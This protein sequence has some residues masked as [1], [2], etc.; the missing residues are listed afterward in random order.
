MTAEKGLSLL[1]I[2]F[3]G[4]QPSLA[5]GCITL[6]S[7]SIIM[8]FL[9]SGFLFPLPSGSAPSELLKE[10]MLSPWV[11]LPGVLL[12][13]KYYPLIFPYGEGKKSGQ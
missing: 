2:V 6:I 4:F 11:Q 5:C 12:G 10:V 7:A 8:Y 13:G 9:L 1:F 3:G